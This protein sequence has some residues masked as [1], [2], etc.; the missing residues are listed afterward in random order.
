VIGANLSLTKGGVLIDKT[1]Q[2]SRSTREAPSPLQATANLLLL[3][4]VLA[5]GAL[6]AMGLTSLFSAISSFIGVVFAD[7]GQ[8]ILW[9]YAGV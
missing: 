7:I 3:A 6:I 4:L 8:S 2:I 5:A 9:A 1:I